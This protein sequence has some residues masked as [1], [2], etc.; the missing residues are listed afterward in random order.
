MKPV[1]ATVPA[2]KSLES[3][4]RLPCRNLFLLAR[5]EKLGTN[6]SS[7]LVCFRAFLEGAKRKSKEAK[8]S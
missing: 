8:G 6:A 1:N 3:L 7:E 5:A 2:K 4:Q